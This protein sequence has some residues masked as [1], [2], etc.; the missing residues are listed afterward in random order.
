MSDKAADSDEVEFEIILEDEGGEPGTTRTIRVY[1]KVRG[2]FQLEI[3]SQCSITFGYFNPAAAGERNQLYD[4]GP[5]G[6]SM[7]ATALRIY[8][9][10]TSKT[11]QVACFLGV[12]GFRDLSLKLTRLRQRVVI[13]S[14]F[15]DDGVGHT[16][17]AQD[18]QRALV[19][20]SEDADEEMP[21]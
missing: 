4:R 14:N 15:E 8:A 17:S 21:F 6:M 19:A 12:D 3:P 13:E 11:P 1:D 18:V 9:G 7:K 5:G 10:K 20:A 16:R 2:D